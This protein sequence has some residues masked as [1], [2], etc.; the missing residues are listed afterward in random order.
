MGEVCQNGMCAPD[1]GGCDPML[2]PD[3]GGG[4]GGNPGGN[5]CMSDA[6]CFLGGVCIDG[7]C[8]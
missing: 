4:D 1:P 8:V 3:C 7:A 6:E 2:D 5:G